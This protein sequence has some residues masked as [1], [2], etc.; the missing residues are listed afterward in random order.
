MKNATLRP[1]VYV[2]M[3]GNSSGQLVESAHSTAQIAGPQQLLLN[4]VT[5]NSGSLPAYVKESNF[6]IQS[7]KDKPDFTASGHGFQAFIG[8]GQSVST[9]VATTLPLTANDLAS[10]IGNN[11][12]LYVVAAITYSDFF[13]LYVFHTNFCVRF[14][15]G[16]PTAPSHFTLVG[17]EELNSRS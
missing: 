5:R 8:A 1:F 13:G 7:R 4:L 11:T 17:C 3:D 10:I 6:T 14:Q 15:P 2:G 9:N 16:T 12:S